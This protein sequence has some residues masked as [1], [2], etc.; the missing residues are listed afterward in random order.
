[1]KIMWAYKDISVTAH[2]ESR[3]IRENTGVAVYQIGP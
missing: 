3:T 1:M 2:I